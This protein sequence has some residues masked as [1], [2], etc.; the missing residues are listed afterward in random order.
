MTSTAVK[1][2]PVVEAGEVLGVVSRR[3]VIRLLAR[4]DELIEAEIDELFRQAGLDWLVTVE[5]GVVVVDGPED[6]REQRLAE[7]LAS[8]VPGAIG[9]RWAPVSTAGRGRP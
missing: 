9:I 1:S 2:L 5:D 3:D 7:T 6:D 4:Q 8:T